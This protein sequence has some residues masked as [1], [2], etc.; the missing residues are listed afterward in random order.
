MADDGGV[1]IVQ[2]AP[3]LVDLVWDDIEHLVRRAMGKGRCEVTPERTKERLQ[4][5]LAQ[6][7]LVLK[8]KSPPHAFVITRLNARDGRNVGEVWLAAGEDGDEWYEPF[9]H[10]FEAYAVANNCS[11]TAVVGRDGWAKKLGKYGYEKAYTV[12][13]KDL[14]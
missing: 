4:E 14:A 8:G 3:P 2:V 9:L 11:Q 7:W 12:V 1:K 13:V 6:L 10:Q 5:G